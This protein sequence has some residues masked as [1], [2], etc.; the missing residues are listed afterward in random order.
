MTYG[1][2]KDYFF[3]ICLCVKM[4]VY[5]VQQVITRTTASYFHAFQQPLVDN[6]IL[7]ELKYGATTE[8]K[9]AYVVV[10]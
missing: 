2:K 6:V 3:S 9:Q 8:V 7:I 4:L 1:H 5:L 10:C